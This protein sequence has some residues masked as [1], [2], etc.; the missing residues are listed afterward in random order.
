LVLKENETG[1]EIIGVK[2]GNR[3]YGTYQGLGGTFATFVDCCLR[4]KALPGFHEKGIIAEAERKD[5]NLSLCLS[6]KRPEDELTEVMDMALQN[7][8]AYPDKGGNAA[9]FIEVKSDN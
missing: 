1:L 9:F 2:I 8:G 5:K 7:I 3:V 6:G 4:K